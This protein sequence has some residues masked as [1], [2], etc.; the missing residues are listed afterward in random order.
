M[1]PGAQ[2]GRC[3]GPGGGLDAFIVGA[4]QRAQI[5]Q[6]LVKGRE[7]GL[8]GEEGARDEGRVFGGAGIDA[9]RLQIPI[10]EAGV[11]RELIL[12][13]AEYGI[14]EGECLAGGRIALGINDEN[15]R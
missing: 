14:G 6:T 8:K 13:G 10:R 15:G 4:I 3:P 7:I 9:E 2:H 5:L 1:E 12:I 11:I